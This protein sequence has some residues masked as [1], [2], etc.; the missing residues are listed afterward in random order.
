MDGKVLLDIYED[1]RTDIERI[2]SWDQV[3]GDH[4]M[5]PPDKR[6]SPADSKAALQQLVALGYIAE[7]NADKAK[8]LDETVREL[9]YNLAQACMDGGIYGQAATILQQLYDT[10]PNEHRSGPNYT[11]AWK[12]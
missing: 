5:H 3:K 6:I 7:P 8:A 10:W 4:G 2:S 12:H 9:D 1:T 11:P